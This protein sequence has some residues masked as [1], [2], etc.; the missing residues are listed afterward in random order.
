[1]L[2][3]LEIVKACKEGKEKAYKALVQLYAPRLMA[4]ALRYLKDQAAAEDAVQESMILVFQSIHRYE[5]K[6]QLYSW[7][8][9]ITVNQ[10]LK[11]LRS[12]VI[13]LHAD[14]VEEDGDTSGNF[15]I[16]GYEDDLVN[17]LNILPQ[18]Y[19]LVFNL[20]VADGYAH[21]EIAELLGISEST[22]RVYLTRARSL[23]KSYLSGINS[24]GYVSGIS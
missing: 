21:A 17:A 13:W 14:E 15:D 10:C 3:D 2:T 19:N 23:L 18:A 16:S 22:S 4:V 11:M 5:H 8:Q 7:L 12:K 9:K 20:Y 6:D 24:K 1:M